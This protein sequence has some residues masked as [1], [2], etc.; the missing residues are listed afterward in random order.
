M[1]PQRL[2]DRAHPPRNAFSTHAGPITGNFRSGKI[3]PVRSRINALASRRKDLS[4]PSSDEE[5][6]AFLARVAATPAR[7]SGGRRG[8]LMFA[9]DATASREPSWD[10]ACQIQAEMFEATSDLGG[11]DV[12][13]CYFRGFR[14]FRASPWVDDARRL[15]RHMTSVR[16]AGG[17][18]QIGR[19]LEHALKETHEDRVNAMVFIGD[20]MEE[21]AD[22]LCATA[23]Q[24]GLL[25]VPV[26]MFHEGRDPVAERCFREISRLSRGAYCRFD[27]GSAEHLRQLLAAVAVYVAGGRKA[28]ADLGARRGGVIR[29]LAHDMDQ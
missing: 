13:L 24:L 27:A 29:Q 9:M 12:Q 8:R 2:F 4:T 1:K 26:F 6:N 19:T 14:E 16:C 7:I 11:L 21:D 10:R 17:A 28:L 25:G 23:G 20:C 22:T 15:A 5:V 18:T 3:A